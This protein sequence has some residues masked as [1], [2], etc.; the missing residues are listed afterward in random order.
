MNNGGLARTAFFF[1]FPKI[2]SSYF[3]SFSFTL[4]VQ[5]K[6]SFQEEICH[7]VVGPRPTLVWCRVFSRK[8]WNH[9]SIQTGHFLL[10]L[11]Y[12]GKNKRINRKRNNLIQ[13]VLPAG[14]FDLAFASATK[15]GETN[16]NEV[17]QENNIF[18]QGH[19]GEAKEQTN[20]ATHVG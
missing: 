16:T 14:I 3:V 18:H 4:A 12:I 5:D 9:Q 11:N 15:F 20:N 1:T 2:F 6:D 19:K 13:F 17:K 7:R 8:C 10:W